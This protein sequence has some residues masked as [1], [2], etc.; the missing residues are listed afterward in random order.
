MKIR[1]K[2]TNVALRVLVLVA[3]IALLV[4]TQGSVVRFVYQGY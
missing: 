1:L 2:W 3:G 4:L